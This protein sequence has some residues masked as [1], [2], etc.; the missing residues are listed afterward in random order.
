MSPL[1]WIGIGCVVILVFC[2]IALGIAGYFAKRAL[3]KISKNPTMAAAELM[4]KANPNL[5][6]VSADEE[7]STLTIK[8]KK[9]GETMTINA[10]DAKNGNWKITSD[11]GSATF[12]ASGNGV[13]IQATDEK[14]QK[15]TTTIG[16][17]AAPQNLPSWIPVYPGGTTQGNMDNV[18]AE[19][20]SG[21]FTVTTKDD[22]S[23]VLDYYEAQLKGAGFKPEKNTYNTSGQ[24]GGSV[25]GKS[26]DGKREAS[27]MV[28]SS[29]GGAQAVVTFTEKK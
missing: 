10:D 22:T 3:D 12:G 16:G 7:H 11:K 6:L 23:K 27:V 1:A 28:S 19:G 25:T 15:S 13:N 20:H 2:G 9:T 24:T 17:T 5:D 29:N 8:D 26:D 14:G 4:V 21:A 18:N